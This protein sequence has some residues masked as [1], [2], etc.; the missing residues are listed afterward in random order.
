MNYKDNFD[1]DAGVLPLVLHKIVIDEPLDWE[2][3]RKDDLCKILNYIK[4]RPDHLGN[5][6]ASLDY[7]WLMTF[8]DGNVSD[9]EIVFPLLM[10]LNI[11]AFFFVITDSIGQQGYLNW[12][13]IKEMSSNGM[14]FGS[15]GHTH[16]RMTEVSAKVAFDEFTNSKKMLEDQLGI[17]ID[18]FSYPY[19]E[20][21]RDLNKLGRRVGYKYIFCSEHGIVGKSNAPIP[22]N[23]INS[24]MSWDDI[25]SILAPNIKK[26][27]FWKME[28]LIK[29]SLKRVLGIRNY[30]NI[31]G[32]LYKVVD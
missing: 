26:R 22:R 16:L 30:R 24:S 9:Y 10:N 5:N 29:Y 2:D 21:S 8:D 7:G 27:I 1:L 12:S 25:E 18:A 14:Y 4:H 28:D 3:V 11:K 20:M 31:R 19:G 17:A 15:H 13:Q 32:A 6:L 23:S